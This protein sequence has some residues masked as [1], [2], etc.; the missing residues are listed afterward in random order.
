[1]AS[2]DGDS[3]DDVEELLQAIITSGKTAWIITESS[4]DEVIVDT[5]EQTEAGV[6]HPIRQILNSIGR[7]TPPCCT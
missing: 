3:E 7:S 6:E 4:M 5:T 1:V 2:A